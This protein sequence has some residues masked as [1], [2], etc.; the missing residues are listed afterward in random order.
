M[1]RADGYTIYQINEMRKM[2]K[3]NMESYYASLGVR[4]P[5]A[6]EESVELRV[7]TLILARVPFDDVVAWYGEKE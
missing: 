2:V 4:N 3:R 5:Y 7:H 1:E 6:A